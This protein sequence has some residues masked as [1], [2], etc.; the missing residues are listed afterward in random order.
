[1]SCE[2][3]A[4]WRLFVHLLVVDMWD[5]LRHTSYAVDRYV[6]LWLAR[7]QTRQEERI[8]RGESEKRIAQRSSTSS[9]GFRHRALGSLGV[10]GLDLPVA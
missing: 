1:M 7:V 4:A 10:N 3:A 6:L 8:S 5:G 9:K 2:V